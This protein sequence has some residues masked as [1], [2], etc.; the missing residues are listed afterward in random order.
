MSRVN[1]GSPRFFRQGATDDTRDGPRASRPA[2]RNRT[3]AGRARL[4]MGLV[5][6]APGHRGRSSA[7]KSDARFWE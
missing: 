4:R 5:E 1:D 7:W 3:K 6:A 2:R